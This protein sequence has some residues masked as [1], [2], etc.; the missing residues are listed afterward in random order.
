I[1]AYE[2]SNPPVVGEELVDLECFLRFLAALTLLDISCLLG[3]AEAA[4]AAEAGDAPEAGDAAEA[5]DAADDAD[6]AEDVEE[7]LEEEGEES[8]VLPEP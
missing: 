8:E 3:D 7:G 1:L 5:A 2:I 6:D 4:E